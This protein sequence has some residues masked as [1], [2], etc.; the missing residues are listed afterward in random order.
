MSLQERLTAPVDYVL[1]TA[2]GP[3]SGWT[4]EN[5]HVPG[6]QG[7]V[8]SEEAK[9]SALD[10]VKNQKEVGQSLT[11]R[12]T[13]PISGSSNIEAGG[14]P[15]W[16]FELNGANKRELIGRATVEKIDSKQLVSSQKTLE[17]HI[18]ND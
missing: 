9:N 13:N 7:G 2:G 14:N 17:R 3:G 8:I 1:V 11:P 18:L 5:G 10:W 6:S 16:W 15:G 12:I 4:A